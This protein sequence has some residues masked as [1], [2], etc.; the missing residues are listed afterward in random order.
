MKKKTEIE[1]ILKSE[2][3]VFRRSVQFLRAEKVSCEGAKKKTRDEGE[4]RGLWKGTRDP[5]HEEIKGI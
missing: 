1:T 4:G 3:S 5:L 2:I